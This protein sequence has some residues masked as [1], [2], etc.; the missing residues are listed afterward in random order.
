M[1]TAMNTI[2]IAPPSVFFNNQASACLNPDGI[3]KNRSTKF[4]I[5]TVVDKFTNIVQATFNAFT[6]LI[7]NLATAYPLTLVDNRTVVLTNYLW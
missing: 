4:S 5:F 2:Q 7:N 3:S 1:I 6:A